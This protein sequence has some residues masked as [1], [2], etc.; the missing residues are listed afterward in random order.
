[1]PDFFQ[2][3]GPDGANGNRLEAYAMLHYALASPLRVNGDNFRDGT[4]NRFGRPENQFSLL[5]H[6]GPTSTSQLSL[7][8]QRRFLS[9]RSYRI[10]P[11]ATSEG[12]VKSLAEMAQARISHFHGRFGDVESSGPQQ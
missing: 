9:W 5:G 3:V 8:F 6:F 2:I 1:M 11:W 7:P 4:E 10:K 12:V